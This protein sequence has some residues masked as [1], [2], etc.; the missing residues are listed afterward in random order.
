MA[1]SAESGPTSQ[2]KNEPTAA[3]PVAP[4]YNLGMM[5]SML[6]M[7]QFQAMKAEYEAVLA[8]FPEA[9][10]ERTAA[11]QPLHEKGADAAL[12]LARQNKGIYIKAAQFVASLQG[13]AG[14]A[15]IPAVYVNR[16]KVLTDQAP[17]AAFADMDAVLLE[18]LGG[19]AHDLFAEFDETPIASASLAQVHRAKTKQG[20]EVAVK[21][22]YPSVKKELASDFA[23]FEQ[24]G[25]QIKPGGFDL[26]PLVRDFKEFI[27][28]E[29]NFDG[30]IYNS[31]KVKAQFAGVKNVKIP[32]AYR[33]L[34]SS[35]VLTQEFV[36]PLIKCNDPVALRDAGLN[37][38]D[39]GNLLA[40]VSARMAL[41]HGFI[42]G[43]PHSGNVY[44]RPSS[45]SPG[46][47]ELVVLD[48]GLY[49]KIE[50]K[51]RLDLC[52]LVN[53]CVTRDGAGMRR[54]GEKFA[55]P[56]HRFFPLILSPLFVFGGSLTIGD[57]QAA[58]EGRLPPDVS[59]RDVGSFLVGLH[60][61]QGNAG[62]LGV[63]HSFGYTRGLLN[64]IGFPEALRVKAFARGAIQGASKTSIF[65]RAFDMWW[66]SVQVDI[67]MLLLRILQPLAPVLLV[68]S[69]R[70]ALL[71]TSTAACVGTV[72]YIVAR[73]ETLF[74]GIRFA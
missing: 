2:D 34:S 24:L 72:G 57:V 13:G 32:T 61:A 33:D 47:A 11:L 37:P 5:R 64:N 1:P 68:P 10:D 23:V 62:M 40:T 36:R 63:L 38:L 4:D 49:H 39:V 19:R 26:L 20:V 51:Q 8:K 67:S 12:A 59:L 66:A 65:G 28:K 41:V 21:V 44:A 6:A 3:A 54:L 29:L 56:L 60:D 42:H 58:L 74:V 14:D 18:E 43:D 17:S 70:R 15:G 52:S 22:Q 35:R 9:S 25:S 69:R 16:L 55:G 27:S 46:K 30:E 71:A 45:T 53:A 7:N 50:S 48:H 73:R 31:E